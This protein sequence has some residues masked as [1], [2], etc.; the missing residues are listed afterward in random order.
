RPR[1]LERG[2]LTKDE[3]NRQ[4]ADQLLREARTLFALGVIRQRH[5]QLI[6]AVSTLEKAQ[7]ADPESLEVRRTLA[8]LYTAV[9]REDAAMAMC[10]QVLDRD[11]YDA[12][13]AFHYARLLRA[14]GRPAEAIPIL[15]K[16]VS[17]KDAQARP[18]RLLFMLADL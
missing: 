13:T 12:E 8:Q 4:K 14:D 5:E 17:G 6:Q 1:V 7:A 18:E 11:P 10:K 3:L 2:P 16:A 9:G 15:E